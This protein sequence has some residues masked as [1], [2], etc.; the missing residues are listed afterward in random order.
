MIAPTQE[1]LADPKKCLAQ[2]VLDKTHIG[3]SAVGFGRNDI[4][5]LRF[6]GRPE[7]AGYTLAMVKENDYCGPLVNTTAD[8][9]NV[10]SHA[11]WANQRVTALRRAIEDGG[12]LICFGETDFTPTS[13]Q[14]LHNEHCEELQAIVDSAPQ[15]IFLVAGTRVDVRDDKQGNKKY[16][17][18]ARIFVSKKLR[19]WNESR[20]YSN[21]LIYHPKQHS[22]TRVDELIWTPSRP[23]ILSYDTDIGKIA[24]LICVDAYNPNIMLSILLS[25]AKKQ[26]REIEYILVPA[27][28]LS[29]K[30]FYA[31]QVMSLISGN[32]VML[33]DACAKSNRGAKPAETAIFIHGRL[34]SDML[35]DDCEKRVGELVSEAPHRP[36]RTARLSLD[37]L[38]Q[39]KSEFNFATPFLNA[40]RG[41]FLDLDD[42]RQSS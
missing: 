24:V 9:N 14:D 17:H 3:L 39:R 32:V 38:K 11:D 10:F 26:L 23:Q 8:D 6:N 22:A 16:L 37:Y 20:F 25:K 30:L 28:N 41:D 19:T 13:D 2:E 7:K 5:P 15:R 1:R 34:L 4:A 36:I 29:P 40:V 21:G 31:C 42:K 35:A 12:E 18:Q 33:V 27:Y